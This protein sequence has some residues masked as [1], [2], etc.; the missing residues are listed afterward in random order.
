MLLHVCFSLM[1]WIPLPK[2]G[3]EMLEMEVRFNFLSVNHED[4]FTE[5]L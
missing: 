2:Q 3:V 4:I 1:N 5:M